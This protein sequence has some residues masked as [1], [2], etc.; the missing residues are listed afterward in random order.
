MAAVAD[1]HW[2]HTT[3]RMLDAVPPPC[4]PSSPPAYTAGLVAVGHAETRPAGEAATASKPAR[5]T[6][7]A[8]NGRHEDDSTHGNLLADGGPLSSHTRGWGCMIAT[9]LPLGLTA[10]DT[11]TD[12]YRRLVVLIPVRVH[13]W[14]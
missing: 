7:E 9:F 14:T 4:K 2:V 6:G 5:S 13:H 10:G 11:E 3:T 1:Q 12:P 8:Q